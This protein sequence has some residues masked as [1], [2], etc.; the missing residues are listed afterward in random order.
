MRVALP[1]EQVS[2]STHVGNKLLETAPI[3]FRRV[4]VRGLSGLRPWQYATSLYADVCAPRQ[5]QRRTIHGDRH[6]CMLRENDV[7]SIFI[8]DRV[9]RRDA[10][11][12]WID[13]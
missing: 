8:L 6:V 3:A 5:A 13:R 9:P 4:Q 7:L 11:C 10:H 12:L 2:L 1:P